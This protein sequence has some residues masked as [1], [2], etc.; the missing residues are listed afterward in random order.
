MSEST[1]Y[2]RLGGEQSINHRATTSPD[3]QR[4]N[5]AVSKRYVKID[6][7]GVIRLVTVVICAGPVGPQARRPITGR[8]NLSTH[9]GMNVSEREFP[10]VLDDIVEALKAHDVGQREHE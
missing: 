9:R 6:R 2:E 5:A 7:A 3:K 10:A 4:R 1:H 8:T